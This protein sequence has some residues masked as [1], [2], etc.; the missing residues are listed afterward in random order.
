MKFRPS[1]V[2]VFR[3]IEARG[4]VIAGSMTPTNND[5]LAEKIYRGWSKLHV[6]LVLELVC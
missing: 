1:S 5:E 4:E 3:Q 2:E 6:K